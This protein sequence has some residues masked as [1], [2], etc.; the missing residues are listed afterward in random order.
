[1]KQGVY[2]FIR[3]IKERVTKYS[4]SMGSNDS[5][6]VCNSQAISLAW[7]YYH[8]VFGL[9]TGIIC[10]TKNTMLHKYQNCDY[11][12]GKVRQFAG[13]ILLFL[14]KIWYDSTDN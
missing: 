13:N 4:Q 8:G 9:A 2:I 1:M 12:T 11:G 5:F 6:Y 14:K 3:G 10:M 7:L